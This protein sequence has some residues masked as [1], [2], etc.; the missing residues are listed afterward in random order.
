M[1][2]RDELE[3]IKF[4]QAQI[5]QAQQS[6]R[7]A[8]KFLDK[9]KQLISQLWRDK[10]G[11]DWTFVSVL[12]ETC[13]SLDVFRYDLWG[14]DLEGIF[15]AEGNL[16]VEEGI[17]D[18]ASRDSIWNHAQHG[19]EALYSRIEVFDIPAISAKDLDDFCEEASERLSFPVGIKVG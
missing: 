10:F 5:D 1:N 18:L 19:Q 6:I 4:N 17:F 9:Q 13:V 7:M 15:D 14:Y 8:N 12:T 11:N 2:I 16:C 3:N